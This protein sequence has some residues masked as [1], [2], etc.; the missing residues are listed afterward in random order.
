MS[1][2]D[3]HPR[4]DPVVLDDLHRRIEGSQWLT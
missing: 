2:V 1:S 3:E 4:I